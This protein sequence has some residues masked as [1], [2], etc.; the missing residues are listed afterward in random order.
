MD[1]VFADHAMA[2]YR[3]GYEVVPMDGSCQTPLPRSGKVGLAK[4]A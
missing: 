2:L 3:A 4:E 1:E